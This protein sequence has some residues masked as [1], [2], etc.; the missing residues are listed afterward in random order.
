MSKSP[1]VLTAKNILHMI[2]IGVACLLF[3]NLTSC[4]NAKRCAKFCSNQDTVI[5]IHD[6]VMTETVKIDSVFSAYIDTIVLNKE[7]ITIRYIKVRD[8]I[9]LSG[10]CVGDTVYITKEIPI[11]F[12]TPK[13]TLWQTIKTN[14]LLW[15]IIFGAFILGMLVVI[16]LSRK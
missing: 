13:L 11:R 10:E 12:T 5:T 6:T 9:Y 1:R 4:A 16:F 8:S 3:I 15:L 7:K 14:T 2:I